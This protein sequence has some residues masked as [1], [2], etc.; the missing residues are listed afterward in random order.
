[1]CN[2]HTNNNKKN[3]RNIYIYL[4][5]RQK[6]MR[7]CVLRFVPLFINDAD[8]CCHFFI[9][10]NLMMSLLLVE[11]DGISFFFLPISSQA[12]EVNCL[13]HCF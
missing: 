7:M 11:V 6:R 13:I 3:K 2:Q 4:S 8:D 1:M 10:R 9:F 5:T 12:S